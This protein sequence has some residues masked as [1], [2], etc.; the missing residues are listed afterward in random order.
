MGWQD[1]RPA[2]NP[3]G[4]P[5][6]E[7]MQNT[8]PLFSTTHGDEDRPTNPTERAEQQHE[9]ALTQQ[10][11]AESQAEGHAE[12]PHFPDQ[13]CPWDGEADSAIGSDASFVC[14]PPFINSMAAEGAQNSATD[15]A[16]HR[17]STMSL[18]PSIYEPVQEFGRTYHSYKSGSKR[19][20]P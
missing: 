3:L 1:L 11:L 7:E 8:S 19:T 16:I 10:A 14:V 20:G 18:R 12:Q 13:S 6:I 9:E 2:L 5:V 15:V 17:S 4:W